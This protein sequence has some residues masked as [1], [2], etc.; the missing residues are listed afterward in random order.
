VRKH[1]GTLA[2]EE[3]VCDR[4]AF[5]PILKAFITARHLEAADSTST[6]RAPTFVVSGGFRLTKPSICHAKRARG[7]GM[8][9]GRSGSEAALDRGLRENAS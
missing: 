3:P 1:G 8:I 2:D 7:I 5:Q 4:N 9:W 6:Q